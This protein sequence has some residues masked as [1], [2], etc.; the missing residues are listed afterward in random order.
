LVPTAEGQRKVKVNLGGR[1][2]YDEDGN[3]VGG[4]WVDMVVEGNDVYI[5]EPD[6]SMILVDSNTAIPPSLKRTW[7]LSLVINFYAKIAKRVSPTSEDGASAA[8]D[9]DLEDSDDASATASDAPGGATNS[10]NAT[11]PSARGGRTAATMAG[12]RRRKA[13]R[14][15]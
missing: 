14:K 9:G 1:Q 6:G 7:F 11:A 8:A 10:K 12:G 5:L 13:V 15:R 3:A 2:R 4:K